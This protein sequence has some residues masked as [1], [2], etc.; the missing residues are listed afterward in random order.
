LVALAAPA[1]AHSDRT[2]LLVNVPT[3]DVLP[4]GSLALSANG[5]IRNMF[6]TPQQYDGFEAGA[7]VRFAPVD[8]L[9]LALTA[10]TLKDYVLGASYRLIDASG[11]AG[12][13]IGVHDIGWNN[14]VSPVGSGPDNAWPDWKYVDSTGRSIRPYENASAFAVMSFPLAEFARLHFGVGRGRYVGYS[15]GR[16]INTDVFLD[17]YTQWAFGLFGGLEVNFGQHVSLGAEFDGRDVNAGLKLSFG[18]VSAA[19]AMTKL[20][21]F[22]PKTAENRF[23]RFDAAV[24]YQFD[25]LFQRRKAPAPPPYEPPPAPEPEPEPEP[26]VVEPVKFDLAPIHFDLDKSIIRP[27][28]A[29]ILKRNAETI[30]AKARAGQKADVI[31]EGHCCP[32]STE[33]YNMGLGARRAEAARE[34]LVGLGVDPALLSTISYGEANPLYSDVPHYYLN[35]RCEF[36][37]KE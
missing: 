15:R 11:G 9:E 3:A 27:G 23:G 6:D 12:L 17:K 2:A 21:G 29:E 18:P 26:A 30:V 33:T 13:A 34:Y 35:R 28:D 19:L 32:Y 37:W 24:S 5:S 16:Y 4:G 31:I 25:N 8:R 36:R 22:T 7:A 20:E 1:P 10:Y 14:H